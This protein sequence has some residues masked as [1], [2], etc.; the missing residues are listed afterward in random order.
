MWSQAIIERRSDKSKNVP[1]RKALEYLLFL[2]QATWYIAFAIKN[3]AWPRPSIS[4]RNVLATEL[5]PFYRFDINPNIYLFKSP[6]NTTKCLDLHSK[7]TH[8][9]YTCDWPSISSRNLN[10]CVNVTM[11]PKLEAKLQ[12]KSFKGS[13]SFFVL[14]QSRGKTGMSLLIATL[15]N[16]TWN[17]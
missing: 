5:D 7:K 14:G 11:L 16:G 17:S 15:C 6:Y 3:V 2:P 10:D 8:Q 1:L 9:S 4:R 12:P 13:I